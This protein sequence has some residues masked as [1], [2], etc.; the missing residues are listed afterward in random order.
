MHHYNVWWNY[1]LP[2]LWTQWIN[3]NESILDVLKWHQCPLVI[4]Y[5]IVKELPCHLVQQSFMSVCNIHTLHTTCE[6]SEKLI[7]WWFG[8]FAE[9]EKKHTW[10]IIHPTKYTYINGRLTPHFQ[11]QWETNWKLNF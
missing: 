11:E 3:S 7:Q 9:L 1:F 8:F 4:V 5:T 2:N 10:N 6:K